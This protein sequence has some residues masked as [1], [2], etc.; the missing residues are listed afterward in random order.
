HCRRQEGE[1]HADHEAA[2]RRI[3]EHA[4]RDL[5]DSYGIDQ[6]QRQ[7]GAELN[8]D[9]EGL[10]EIGVV[11]TEEPLHQQQMAGRGHREKYRESLDHAEKESLQQ[12]D[13]HRR[14][15][16]SDCDEK[17]PARLRRSR[18]SAFAASLTPEQRRRANMHRSLV[19]RTRSSH[20]RAAR[21]FANFGFKSGTR[22]IMLLVSL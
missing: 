16:Q 21:V 3:A 10:A 5:P 6:Q 15:P 22:I 20:G 17:A 19:P 2:R 7:D 14:T 13:W 8:Q 1:Q 18:K 12:I 11:E 9:R 4:D